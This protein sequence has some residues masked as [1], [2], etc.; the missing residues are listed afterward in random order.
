MGSGS[1][2]CVTQQRALRPTVPTVHVAD[3]GI[4]RIDV[5]RG[6]GARA[7][8]EVERL[9]FKSVHRLGHV[10]VVDVAPKRV[11]C[12][13]Q[14][15]AIFQPVNRQRLRDLHVLNLKVRRVG[16]AV[17]FE[18]SILR[19]QEVRPEISRPQ[20]N[21]RGVRHSNVWRHIG[22]TCAERRRFHAA[23]RACEAR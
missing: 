11:D 8:D 7:G 23:G 12:L 20:T 16:V 9:L 4:F 2:D 22:L 15:L 5:E 10:R 1:P 6:A 13:Q 14:R 21:A 17:G 18:R 3:F 19:S